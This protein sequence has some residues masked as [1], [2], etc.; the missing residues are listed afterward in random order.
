MQSCASLYTA[1]CN[2]NHIHDL[3]T[4]EMKTHTLSPVLGKVYANFVTLRLDVLDLGNF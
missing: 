4:S 2:T 1:L 3:R